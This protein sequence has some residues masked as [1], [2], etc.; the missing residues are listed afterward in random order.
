MKT[1]LPGEQESV[2]EHVGNTSLAASECV[3]TTSVEADLFFKERQVGRATKCCCEALAAPGHRRNRRPGPTTARSVDDSTSV[4]RS[5]CGV[6]WSSRGHIGQSTTQGW[7]Q[8][9]ILAALDRGSDPSSRI[10]HQSPGW[11]HSQIPNGYGCGDANRRRLGHR[12]REQR[13]WDHDHDGESTA[14]PNHQS[15]RI[16]ARFGTSNDSRY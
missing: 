2:A 9:Q 10:R 8:R 15:G 1:I 14:V 13:R 6:F 11:H 16:G 5:D 4:R 3:G 12:E 7:F